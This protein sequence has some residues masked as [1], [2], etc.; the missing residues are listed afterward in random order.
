MDLQPLQPS[1]EGILKLRSKLLSDSWTLHFCML[2]GAYLRFS[3]RALTEKE[4][5]WKSIWVR[6][7]S[8]LGMTD[9]GYLNERFCQVEL[10]PGTQ[11]SR[12]EFDEKII[13]VNDGVLADGKLASVQLTCSLKTVSQWEDALHMAKYSQSNQQDCGDL[14]KLLEFACAMKAG[15]KIKDRM[16]YLKVFTECFIGTEATDWIR[17]TVGCSVPQAVSIGDRMLNC[18]LIH[19][20]TFEHPFCNH[21]FFYRFSEIVE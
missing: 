12:G 5:E 18:G 21:P 1:M 13:N 8:A 16:Y 9:S 15:I 10:L 17:R 14:G 11:V 3:K 2:R 6:E 20:V 19:H 4:A 7:K